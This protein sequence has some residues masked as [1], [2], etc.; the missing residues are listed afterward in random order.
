MLADE[1]FDHGR[2]RERRD[3]PHLAVFIRGNL[4]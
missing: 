1:L 2:I 4:S 3:V